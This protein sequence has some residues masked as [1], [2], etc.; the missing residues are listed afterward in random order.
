M[1]R[2]YPE[3]PFQT[4]VAP[5]QPDSV[6][7]QLQPLVVR[8]GFPLDYT[9]LDSRLIATRR[10]DIDESPLF[11]SVV[12]GEEEPGVS[13]RV[14]VAGYQDTPSGPL[15]VNPDDETLWGR[16]Q[17]VAADFSA[18]LGGTSP[19]GPGGVEAAPVSNTDAEAESGD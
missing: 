6:F 5:G 12:V 13:S 1:L 16:V 17:Q 8:Y 2:G 15:R 14:W 11:L 19:T 10:S 9:R 18:E 7:F 4:F 3:Y